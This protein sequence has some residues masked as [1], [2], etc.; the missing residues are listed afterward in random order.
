MLATD[1]MSDVATVAQMF[2][3]RMREVLPD[4]AAS[5]GTA[6]PDGFGNFTLL[7]VLCASNSSRLGVLYRGDCF[8]I[9]ISVADA[10]GPAEQQ[11]IIGDDLARAV[12]ATVDFLRDIVAGRVLVD[13]VRYRLLWFQPYCLAF[14]RE[15]SRRPRGRVVRT[16]SWSGK[17]D[18]VS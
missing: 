12:A 14:F 6:M 9:S 7:D 18:P 10:R 5:A 2:Q 11:V 17:D 4:F 15:T 1:A 16:L 13:I 8:E 3:T